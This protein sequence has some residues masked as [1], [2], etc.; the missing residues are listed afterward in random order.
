MEITLLPSTIERIRAALGDDVDLSP[1][2]VPAVLARLA[3]EAPGV[4]SHVLAE[5][6]GSQVRLDS[7]R[8]LQ[9][10]RRRGWLRRILFWWGEYESEVGDRL[11]AKRHIAA[12][13]P[14]GLAGLIVILLGA[15][16]IVGHRP[17]SVADRPP[18]RQVMQGP[19]TRVTTGRTVSR[20]PVLRS[21]RLAPAPSAADLMVGDPGFPPISPSWAPLAPPSPSRMPSITGAASPGNPVVFTRQPA[22]ALAGGGTWIRPEA[23]SAISPIVYEGAGDHTAAGATPDRRAASVPDTADPTYAGGPEPEAPPAYAAREDVG[24][25]RKRRWIVGQRLPARLSTGVVVIAGG[26]PMPVVAESA[27]PAGTW[28]GHATLGPEGLVQLAFTFAASGGSGTVR[29]IGLDPARLAP[30]L[31]GRTALRH[32]QALG[33]V[34]AAALQATAD[35]VQALARQGQLTL[36][37]GWAQLAAGPPAPP[38]T[39]MAARLA[40]GLDPRGPA[41]GPVATTELDPGAPIV[42]LLTE[43][44]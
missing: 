18:A 15:S 6:S 42:I 29:G 12:A 43:V 20:V 33:A 37:D 24:A 19:R 28:L 4:Y 30:G 25:S 16:R 10:R 3:V 17:A 36:V 1:G 38:W 8:A 39:Y 5:I 27:D 14:L 11:I 40:Q 32:P 26:P 21:P 23:A 2:G 41:S 35:Y 31:A 44:P 7:E 13:V 9:R 34:V 22:A